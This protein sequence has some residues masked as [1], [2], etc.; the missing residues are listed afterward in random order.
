MAWTARLV[1][2]DLSLQPQPSSSCE[3]SMSLGSCYSAMSF[4]GFSAP[5]AGTF[6]YLKCGVLLC[7]TK[8][9]LYPYVNLIYSVNVHITLR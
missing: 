3:L 9:I 7:A 1:I 8:L 4:G 5:L 6:G 2:L